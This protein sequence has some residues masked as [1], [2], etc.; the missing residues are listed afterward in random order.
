MTAD[1]DYQAHVERELDGDYVFTTAAAIAGALAAN[2]PLEVCW[3]PGD[4]TRYDLIIT[5]VLALKAAPPRIAAFRGD[6][7]TPVEWDKHCALGVSREPGKA[8]VAWIEH[9]AVGL[10]LAC[11]GFHGGYVTGL[12]RTVDASGYALAWLFN[13]T[14]EAFQA[15]VAL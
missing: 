9:G 10:D 15:G 2:Q 7:G 1:F 14:G 12:F 3:Q 6:P 4:G 11:G 8:V 5:P 13:A